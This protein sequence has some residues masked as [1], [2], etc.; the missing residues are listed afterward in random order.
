MDDEAKGVWK[1]PFPFDIKC[2]PVENVSDM[3]DYQILSGGLNAHDQHIPTHL[4]PFPP[5]HTYSRRNG[6]KK[7]SE[8]ASS[9]NIVSD[10]K[11]TK[12]VVV[13]GALN[14]LSSIEESAD[15]HS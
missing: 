5:S 4:P 7:R 8:I 14:A 1:Q 9:A 6:S 10:A 3:V 2:F 11:R 12:A 15:I 13:K